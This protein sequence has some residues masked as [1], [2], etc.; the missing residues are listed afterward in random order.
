MSRSLRYFLFLLP[1]FFISCSEDIFSPGVED[2]GDPNGNPVEIFVDRIENVDTRGVANPKTSFSEGEVIHL[3]ATFTGDDTFT[4]ETHYKA[5]KFTEG[6]WVPIGSKLYWPNLATHGSFRAY[7]VKK[8]QISLELADIDQELN[9]SEIEDDT[10]PLY[11]ET[12]EPLEWGHKVN[13]MFRHICTHLT[14]INLDPDIADYFWLI[15]N[16]KNY[17]FHNVFTLRRTEGNELVSGFSSQG[18]ASYKN[19][20]YVQHKSETEYTENIKTGSRVSFFLEPGNYSDLE[21]RTINNY[22]YLA[23]K[24]E[25]TSNLLANK[26]YVVNIKTS[27]GVTFIEDPEIWDEDSSP[28]EVDPETF[29]KSVAEGTDYIVKDD[30]DNDVTIL[31]STSSGTLLRRNVD[32][33]SKK[34][35]PK[36]DVPTGRYFDGGNHYIEN[37]ATNIF[38]N[39][40]GTIQHLCLKNIDCDVELSNEANSDRSRWG[41]ICEFNDGV[42][43]N[44]KIKNSTVRFR[45][46]TGANVATT[47]FNVGSLTGSNSGTISSVVYEGNISISSSQNQVGNVEATVN[48]GGFT[49]QSIGIL[50]DISPADDTASVSVSSALQ[51]NLCVLYIGGVVGQCSTNIQEI[52]LR[53]VSVDASQGRG[54]L[55]DAG[56][57]AGR[58]RGTAGAPSLMTSCTVTGS[59]KGFPVNQYDE[60]TY[61]YPANSYT[62]GLAGYN[63]NYDVT[64]CRSICNV[65]MSMA[66]ESGSNVTIATGGAFGRIINNNDISGNYI[67]GSVLTGPSSYIGNFAGIVPE[68]LS[69]ADYEA[70]RNIVKDIIA[71]QF[72]GAS[73]DGQIPVDDDR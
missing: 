69:W 43:D 17:E 21:L 45:I 61:T 57:I 20:V 37:I 34:D 12:E 70:K 25:A 40:H 23:Y 68:A 73:I 64:D 52:S 60:G 4:P 15:N 58:L 71:G 36:F 35:F 5:F 56:G 26:P 6:K 66:V 38:A 62:G 41:V 72:V 48:V 29:L 55:G 65:E 46:G 67:L 54:L 1:L 47:V 8:F 7:F 50:K 2:L 22:S 30:N 39:N 10:D 9:L 16:V 27:K 49:G 28:V 14:F 24:S 32:F 53:N 42:I 18:D 3:E 59:V 33:K 63:Y 19:V 44:L 51:G 11:A 31:Q 13:L